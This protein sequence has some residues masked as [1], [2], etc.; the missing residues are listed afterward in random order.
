MPLE[1]VAGAIVPQ[2]GEQLVPPCVSVQFTPLL[3]ESL[4][5]VAVN[6]CVPPSGIVALAGARDTEMA[7]IVMETE[8]VTVLSVAEA[9]VIVTVRLAV[10]VEGAV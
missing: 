1:V 8:A 3:L 6:A 4:A 5:T 9:A 2:P 10:S 7:V